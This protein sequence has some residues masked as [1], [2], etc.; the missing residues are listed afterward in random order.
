MIRTVLPA[1]LLLLPGAALAQNAVSADVSG[2]V[3]HTDNATLAP[4]G[5]TKKDPDTILT[6]RPS[7]VG[8]AETRGIAASLRYTL[9]YYHY[10]KDTDLSRALHDLA[11]DAKLIWWD[12][13]DLEASEDLVPVP[14]DF[15]APL[16]NPVN[17]VQ[18]SH[19]K[20]HVDYEHEFGPLMRGE[21]GYAGERVNYIKVHRGDTLPPEYLIH[22]PALSIDRGSF[23]SSRYWNSSWP[24]RS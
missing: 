17:Q 11:A 19:T 20:G 8:K 13:V 3:E 7:V 14:L 1:L 21:V 4:E 16:D 9:S 6:V 5:T 22:G 23:A 18:S 24:G 12:N 15:G 2:L 10:S